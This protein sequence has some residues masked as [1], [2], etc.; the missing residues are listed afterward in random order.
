MVA[1]F[2][3]WASQNARRN[4]PFADNCTLQDDQGGQLPVD[5]LV[6]ASLYPFDLEGFP[7]LS[8]IQGATR[9]LVWSDSVTGQTVGK[10]NWQEGSVA[11]QVYDVSGY[12][13]PIGTLV[14][15][16]GLAAIESNATRTFQPTATALT[17]TAF[18]PLN[19]VGV[20]GIILPD[21][22][23]VT[24]NV[25]FEGQD[26]V[27]VS[28]IQ[29]GSIQILRVD[30]V[31]VAAP[32]AQQCGTLGAPICQVTAV[33]SPGSAFVISQYDP[34]TLALTLNGVSLDQICAASTNQQRAAIQPVAPAQPYRAGHDACLPV[35]PPPGPVPPGAALTVVFPVCTLASGAFLLAAP[36]SLDYINPV[37]IQTQDNQQGA[38]QLART[39]QQ[40]SAGAAK[41]FTDPA[42]LAGSVTI[43]IQGVR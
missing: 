31:G 1:I 40:G 41:D 42:S 4:Y 2:Q 28:T 34:Y 8:S 19:Q 15:G 39:D 21:G 7:Y 18:V 6:D 10:A 24:G 29:A 12:S 33:R 14:F 22:T 13:R 23:L 5:F 27:M 43:Q 25:T 11:S 30:V 32:D 37:A 26:G 38:Q 36:S 9:T 20:R 17:P 3:E 16:D 35:P